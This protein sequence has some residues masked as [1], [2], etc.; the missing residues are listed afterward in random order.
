MSSPS[1]VMG[2]FE[3]LVP[4][5]PPFWNIEFGAFGMEQPVLHPISVNH[6]LFD[7]SYQLHVLRIY[8]D[9]L[10]NAESLIWSGIPWL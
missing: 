2:L 1:S 10:T 9:H 6:T 8:L 3:Q 4:K 5:V 7:I